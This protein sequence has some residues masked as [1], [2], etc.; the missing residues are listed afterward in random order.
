MQNSSVIIIILALVSSFAFVDSAHAD[1]LPANSPLSN[2][3]M[4][5]IGNAGVAVTDNAGVIYWNP[6]GFGVSEVISTDFT[7]AGPKLKLPGSW[8]FFLSNSGSGGG[9][10]GLGVIRQ[11]F[12]SDG[13]KYKSFEVIAPLTHQVA[14]GTIPLGFSLKYINERIDEADWKSGLAIDGGVM[15]LTPTGFKFGLSVKNIIGSNLHTFGSQTWLGVS[16]GGDGYPVLI[17]GQVRAERLRNR[18]YTSDNF[19]IGMNA[20]LFENLPQI[21]IGVMRANAENR[22]TCGLG[23]NL[24]KQNSRM[25]YSFSVVSDGWKD[26]AH[27]ITYSWELKPSEPTLKGSRRG[28]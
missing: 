28:F 6:A 25:D 13:V 16:W 14:A 18:T 8:S 24:K 27:F 21:R 23:F 2:A 3:F 10:F 22:M 19:N 15:Y 5:G 26:K 4:I 9:R 7:A 11:H 20:M 1:P 17:S 12:V